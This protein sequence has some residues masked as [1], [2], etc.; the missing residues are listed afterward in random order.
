M[1]PTVVVEED[2]EVTH[3]NVVINLKADHHTIVTGSLGA[4]HVI[5]TGDCLEA[6]HGTSTEGQD[7]VSVSVDA[8]GH[9][10]IELDEAGLV[11]NVYVREVDRVTESDEVDHVKDTGEEVRME[12]AADMIGEKILTVKRTLKAVNLRSEFYVAKYFLPINNSFHHL[13]D[14]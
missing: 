12:P 13:Q 1:I 8:A 5:V 7:H 9:R 3:L 2:L 14:S 10:V 11:I 6:D 4:N